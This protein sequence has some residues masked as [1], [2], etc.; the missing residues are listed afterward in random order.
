MKN[1]LKEKL[2]RGEAVIGTF[3]G[4]GH[5]DVAEWLSRLGFDWLLLDGE[6]SPISLETLQ[7]MM[8]G[9]NGST[10]VPLVRP[11]WNDPVIIKRVLDVGAYGVLIPWVNSKEQAEQAV[12]ACKYPP[13][14]LRGFGPRRAG[15][16]DPD[17]F[18]TAND[19][20]LVT[21]QI[22]TGEALKNLDDIMAVPGIDACYIG[23]YDLS[24][25]LGF[26]V[27]P[28]WDE[29]RYMA[30]IDRVLEVA[31]RHGKPAGMFANMEN[32]E[33]ALEKG[34]RF[35]SVDNDD[36]FLLRGARMALEKANR[37]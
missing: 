12:S 23:P 36:I 28:K 14:G 2:N 15:M 8:Q 30:A 24:V 27:P 5:P 6:H 10:C 22:E 4:I 17:Y 32:I 34:F 31:A 35:N 19:E 25:S 13:Q 1:P 7:V 26:G 20:I 11:Q 29:P 16:F 21:V 18:T 33:W 9:M 3:V 37:K